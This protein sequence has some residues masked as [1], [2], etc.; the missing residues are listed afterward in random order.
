MVP[1]STVND[2]VLCKFVR[3][4]GTTSQTNYKM[5]RN[6]IHRIESVS[7][8]E[9]HYWLIHFKWKKKPHHYTI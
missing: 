4:A 1:K 5:Y 9:L 7:D 6:E 2:T 3:A 8:E